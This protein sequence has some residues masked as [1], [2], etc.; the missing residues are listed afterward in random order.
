MPRVYHH[1]A[2][3]TISPSTFSQL[4]ARGYDANRMAIVT[5]GV[6]VP[7]APASAQRS[8]NPLLIYLGR[9][10]GYKGVD[11]LI[12]ALPR[13]L[14]RFPDARLAIVGQGPERER[15][16][17]LGWSLG[18][19]ASVRFYGY[20]DREAKDQLL[21]EA[22]TAVCPSAFEGW[23]VV[24]L[25]ANA[26]GI[27]VVAARVSGLIDAVLDGETGTLVPYGDPGSLADALIDLLSDSSRRHSMGVAGQAWA[28]RHSW[29]R[30][31]GAFLEKIMQ[32]TAG[33]ASP[34][35]SLSPEISPTT[36]GD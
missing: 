36:S 31:A 34:S 25:E 33:H 23:G 5:P 30:S 16:E 22:W 1:K 3:V 14:S 10:K 4:L 20:L 32:V 2:V 9:L 15:L 8:K 17:R 6:E 24:C 27:P 13:V 26:A 28:A 11:V 7:R 19:A 35:L 18:L 21:A 12:R 29:D